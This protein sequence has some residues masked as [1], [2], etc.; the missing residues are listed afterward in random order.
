MWPL[1]ATMLLA[2]L[3]GAMWNLTLILFV[4]QRFHSPVLAGLA[5]F[6]SWMPG[7]LVSPL[8]GALID[9]FGR[10]RLI[11]LDM[12]VSV[13]G[14]LLI[15]WLTLAGSLTP[16]ALLAVVGATSL[17]GT[18]T[19]TGTRSLI[20][21]VVPGALWER[22]NALDAGT[23]NVAM[24]AGPALAGLLFAAFGGV[25]ALLALAGVWLAAALLVSAVKDVRSSAPAAGNVLR[26]AVEGLRY[27]LRNPVL[28]GLAVLMVL[29]NA[30]DGIF[31]VALPVLFRSSPYGGS[32]VVGALWSAF[33]LAAVVGAVLMGRVDTEARERRII[34]LALLG[35]GLTSCLVAL[36]PLAAQPLLPAAVGLSIGGVFAG[37]H[38]IAMFSLRQRSIDPALVGRAMAVSMSFNAIGFPL[39][40]ALAGPAI[41]LSLAGAMLLAAGL[42]GAAGLLAVVLLPRPLTAA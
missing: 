3:G 23:F 35:G 17:T 32:A 19:L 31:Q 1:A 33:G 27:F 5:T 2:R 38:D 6:M 12:G 21:L 7:L 11:G 26:E 22:A 36:S 9:R 42:I 24:I 41:E 37:A 13:L 18:L 20:P 34:C 16:T 29:T 8:A 30:G 15:V 14:V 25:G 39:G 4:L 10:A 40:S 28:S